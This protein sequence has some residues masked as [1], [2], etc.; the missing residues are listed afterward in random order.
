MFKV[1]LCAGRVIP[2]VPCHW[3]D[4]PAPGPP[5][6]PSFQTNERGREEKGERESGG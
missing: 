2:P 4:A 3:T 5:P 6:P 1:S